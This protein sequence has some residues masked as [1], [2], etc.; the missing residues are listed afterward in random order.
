MKSFIISIILLCSLIVCSVTHSY[1]L[2]RITG[3]I[4]AQNDFITE[5]IYNDHYDEALENIDVLN[6]YI[7]SKRTILAT[8]LDHNI[9]TKIDDYISQISGYSSRQA[10]TDAIVACGCLAKFLENL[11]ENYKLKIGNIL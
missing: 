8:T 4:T 5:C 3:N 7:D 6:Q 10:K 9:L 11:P 1:A 2:D